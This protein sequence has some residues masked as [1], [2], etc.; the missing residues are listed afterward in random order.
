MWRQQQHQ[1]QQRQCH[2]QF[3]H[4]YLQN[5]LRLINIIQLKWNYNKKTLHY[6]QLLERID[7]YFKRK[8]SSSNSNNQ[9]KKQLNR[10]KNTKKRKINDSC[11]MQHCVV[12]LIRNCCLQFFSFTIQSLLLLIV[13]VACLALSVCVLLFVRA[14]V[15]SEPVGHSSHKNV[16]HWCVIVLTIGC[17]RVNLFGC[18]V[19]VHISVAASLRLDGSSLSFCFHFKCVAWVW[20]FVLQLLFLLLLLCV[21]CCLVVEAKTK[22]YRRWIKLNKGNTKENNNNSKRN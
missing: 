16:L 12:C 10:N 6:L 18:C 9:N 15:F 8:C 13:F 7:K 20:I 17:E 2:Q 19:Y 11:Y 3:H 14:R 1:Q 5:C 21:V 22:P 4:I